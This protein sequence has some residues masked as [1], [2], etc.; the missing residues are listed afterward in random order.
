V[1]LRCIPNLLPGGYVGAVVIE[2]T[3]DYV[4]LAL[5]GRVELVSVKHREEDQPPWNFAALVKEHVFRDLHGIWKQIGEDGDYVFESNRGFSRPLRSVIEKAADP[6][7][8]EAAKLASAIGVNAGEAARFASRL[9]LTPEP[10]PG[11]RHIR[12]V[13]AAR[14]AV[15]MPQLGLDPRLARA[16]VTALEERVAAVAVDRPLEPEQRVQALAGL[17]REVRDQGAASVGDFMLTIDELREVVAATAAGRRAEARLR[18]PV[19]DPL[20]SGRE[21]ELASLRQLLAPGPDGLV[22]PVVLR[23]CLKT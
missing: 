14:L 21:A 5:D 2:W 1:V 11:R 7:T 6:G 23:A 8:R 3:S 12:D 9:I 16:C 13:A 17:M 18:P 10:V 19:S 22:T 4:V 20:F 15:V